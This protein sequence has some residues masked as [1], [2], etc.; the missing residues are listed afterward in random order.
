MQEAS[1]N[2]SELLQAEEEEKKKAEK[3]RMKNK[4]ASHSQSR[5]PQF[6]YDMHVYTLYVALRVAPS[7]GT[8]EDILMGT[9]LSGGAY[10]LTFIEHSRQRRFTACI[11]T[12][13]LWCS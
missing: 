4:K 11:L 13:A 3:R 9:R 8:G 6:K 5:C 7:G 2:A 1:K 12:G 10:M